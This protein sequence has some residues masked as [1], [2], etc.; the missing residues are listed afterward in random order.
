MKRV[1]VTCLNVRDMQNVRITLEK[2]MANT[3]NFILYTIAVSVSLITGV[4]WIAPE[5]FKNGGGNCCHW[6]VLC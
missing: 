6:Q 4:M 1:S 2:K 5:W 3:K